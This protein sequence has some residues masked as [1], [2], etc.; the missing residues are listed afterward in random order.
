MLARLPERCDAPREQ[1]LARAIRLIGEA[2]ARGAK[3][4]VLPELF[5]GPYFCQFPDDRTAFTQGE[6]GGEE[7]FTHGN[8]RQ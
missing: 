7:Y 6:N 4:I 8:H 3:L 1:N 2:A 5:L